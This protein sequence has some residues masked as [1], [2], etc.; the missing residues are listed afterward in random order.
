VRVLR[1]LGSLYLEHDGCRVPL[2]RI[3]L[4][5]IVRMTPQGR[6]VYF[7]RKA[8]ERF[9]GGGVDETAGRLLQWYLLPAREWSFEVPGDV[10]ETG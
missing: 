6:K 2:E 7:R 1:H 10:L 8:K 9:L 4:A 3:D 5:H